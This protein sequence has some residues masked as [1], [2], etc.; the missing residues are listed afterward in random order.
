MRFLL[1][2]DDARTRIGVAGALERAGHG[3]DRVT[4]LRLAAACADLRQ[5]D[6]VLVGLQQPLRRE[7]FVAAVRGRHATLPIAVLLDRLTG[8]Q[9]PR[10]EALGAVVVPPGPLPVAELVERLERLVAAGR[11]DGGRAHTVDRGHILRLPLEKRAKVHAR[12]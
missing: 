2:S 9:A 5:T 10:L 12:A 1:A 3:V 11:S 7:E 6:G 8:W 4:H